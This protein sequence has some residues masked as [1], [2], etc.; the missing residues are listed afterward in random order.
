M[1]SALYFEK[2]G[3]SIVLPIVQYQKTNS[4]SNK[5]EITF[6]LEK[7]SAVRSL[8][9]K[10]GLEGK[11]PKERTYYS[12][13]TNDSNIYITAKDGLKW[14]LNTRTLAANIIISRSSKKP[15]RIPAFDH[16]PNSWLAGHHSTLIP[17]TRISSTC[18]RSPLQLSCR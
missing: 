7:A 14:M 2:E 6:T 12:F 11:L 15:D 4:Y 5:G 18:S 1:P 10:T 13:N 3:K 8:E 17:I 16:P 9:E